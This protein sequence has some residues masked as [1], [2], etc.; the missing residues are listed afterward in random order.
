MGDRFDGALAGGGRA[1]L[2]ISNLADALRSVSLNEA[3]LAHKDNGDLV[4]LHAV[5]NPYAGGLMCISEDIPEHS[6]EQL[7]AAIAKSQMTSMLTD[8]SRCAKY[9]A[10]IRTVVNVRR[11]PTVLDIGAGTGL[12]ALLAARAGASNVH[13]VEM[14]EP[15]AVL[16]DDIVDANV[17]TEVV[18]VHPVRSTDLKVDVNGLPKRADVLV[19][20]IF[21]SA[22]LGEACLPV[23]RDARRR[24]LSQD[25]T[26]IPARATVYA[27]LAQSTFLRRFHDFGKDFPLHRSRSGS[28][29][30]GH[31]K[32]IPV[33]LDALSEGSDFHFISDTTTVFTFDF[34]ED[35]SD[36]RTSEI[37]FSRT[38]L[39]R[40][41]VVF[42]W[43]QLD[44][45]GDGSITYSSAPGAEPWQDHWLQMAHPLPGRGTIADNDDGA[46]IKLIATHDDLRIRFALKTNGC[47][48]TAC[49]CG[50]HALSGGP[51]RVYELGDEKRL[52]ALDAVV[53]STLSTARERVPED[54]RLRVL[55]VSDG[56][57]CAALAARTGR[58]D[59]EII[60]V[61]EDEELS[62]FVFSQVTRRLEDAGGTEVSHEFD[63]L[64]DFIT[65]EVE[66]R[67]EG[68]KGEKEDWHGV[69]ILLSEP[70][71]R[72]F[73]GWPLAG[74]GNLMVQ[75]RAVAKI[76][77]P[78]GLV[79]VPAAARV[80]AQAVQFAPHTLQKGVG[81]VT[82]VLGVNH[83]PYAELFP[84]ETD[85]GVRDD[86]ISL[87][88]FQYKTAAVG[89]E[90]MLR[91]VVIGE[92]CEGREV[93][94]VKTPEKVEA[95][96]LW[97]EYEDIPGTRVE[98]REVVWL[99]PGEKASAAA[100]GGLAIGTEWMAE[101]G[102][103][104]VELR[105]ASDAPA[106]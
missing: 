41:D 30:M 77:A 69:D 35:N 1:S 62:S 96:V 63:T 79:V 16:A 53:R 51:Y 20:E 87:P 28:S 95:V 93:A 26:I 19:T 22:L 34:S 74:L 2:P 65:R 6:D 98:R 89:D 27:R 90:T 24:L 33:H 46:V 47:P 99:H 49:A 84:A 3:L 86:R 38:A 92:E 50:L 104:T 88:M 10:A 82:N 75:R 32:P 8:E 83:G 43:W 68:E 45:L 66:L 18:Q 52:T 48:R 72:G 71:A 40:A 42:Y 12:L 103:W 5:Q 61:E 11:A 15:L 70:Y 94:L 23:I 56:A 97:V 31:V 60:S 67:K 76:A 59:I 101:S 58:K 39:G 4:L 102:T 21:D 91:M 73:V 7:L 36:E 80:M 81:P 100:R 37:S 106:Q 13:A 64:S 14:Y 9:A 105:P 44:L 57:V 54:Q 78:T 55:D 29:C 85:W 25:A 17:M